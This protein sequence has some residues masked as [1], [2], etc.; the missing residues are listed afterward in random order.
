MVTGFWGRK[1]GMTQIFTDNKVIPVT[2]I[3]TG[4]WIIT[5]LKN[6]ERDGYDSIQIGCLKNKYKGQPFA[7]HWLKKLNT[8]FSFV[9]EVH[10][11]EPVEGLKVGALLDATI[12]VSEGDKVDVIGTSKGIGFQGV[13]KRHDFNGPPGS[14]GSDMGNRPGSIGFM[15][16]CGKVIKGKKMPGHTGNERC[17]VK[18]LEVVKL[19]LEDGAVVLIKG[20]IPGKAGSPVFIRKV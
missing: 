18:G 15:R 7:A 13:V 3:R 17:T 8:Y 10:M 5:A 16:E 14:H 6:K 9:R 19:G 11:S 4:D 12:V 1:I 20:S 2:A